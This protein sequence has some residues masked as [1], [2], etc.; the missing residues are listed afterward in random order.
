MR[1]VVVCVFL[2][3]CSSAEPS[4]TTDTAQ[5]TCATTSCVPGAS[6]RLPTGGTCQCFDAGEWSCGAAPSSPYDAGLAYDS[7]APDTIYSAPPADSMPPPGTWVTQTYAAG[8]CG[9]TLEPCSDTALAD[10]KTRLRDVMRKC[11]LYCVSLILETTEDGCP[12]RVSVNYEPVAGALS[13]FEKSTAATNIQCG[14][15]IAVEE[16]AGCLD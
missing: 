9:G 12:V 11:G 2:F 4:T 10:V 7:I 6:C 1:A 15:T 16:T 13:C 8:G 14:P 3:G 5:P